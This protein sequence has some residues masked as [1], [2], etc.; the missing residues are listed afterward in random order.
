MPE[1]DSNQPQG[2]WWAQSGP[3][4]RAAVF[5]VIATCSW[6]MLK[7]LAPLLRP[8]LMAILLCY[9]IVPIH[10]IIHKGRSELKTIVLM[11]GGALILCLLV[12]VLLYGSV[13][14]MSDQMPRLTARAQELTN[15][16]IAWSNSNLPRWMSQA[17][18]DVI[19]A[20]NKT[21]QM[22]QD[23]SKKA[24]AYAA[25]LLLETLVVGLYVIFLL[26]EARQLPH[27]IRGGFDTTHAVSILE[28]MRS[29]NL[30]ISSY[31][32]AKVKSSMI[33]ALPVTVILYLFG[34]KFAGVWGI[35]TF[36]CNFI[37]YVGSVI[38]CGSPLI[39]G[40]LDL[41]YGWQPLAVAILLICCHA[42]PRLSFR[43]LNRRRASP[44]CWEMIDR[45]E[46]NSRGSQCL[47]PG[48]RNALK[49]ANSRSR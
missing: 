38:A 48:S 13:V 36:L 3:L 32:K 43:T 10:A 46:S 5:L 11:T 30:S 22:A 33:L 26:I 44:G 35:L 49:T 14:E 17:T 7:E 28:A 40:F 12:G 4:P 1:S 19:R 31:L 15:D 24:L 2:N 47:T 39:F 42:P 9:V 18:D 16:G 21:A 6:F 25:D 45:Q 29:I 27:R 37:P 20:E 8:L 23:F 34:V 41:P